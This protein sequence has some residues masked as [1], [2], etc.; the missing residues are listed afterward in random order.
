MNRRQFL[1]LGPTALLAAHAP[2]ELPRASFAGI[3]F[4]VFVSVP[5]RFA[6]TMLLR[7]F[8]RRDMDAWLTRTAFR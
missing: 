3:E 2:A 1:A 8:V 6:M 5:R 4:P 7:D